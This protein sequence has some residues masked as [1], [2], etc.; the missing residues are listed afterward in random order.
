MV[1]IYKVE[2]KYKCR[3]IDI[4]IQKSLSNGIRGIGSKLF[5]CLG[6]D[7]VTVY[8]A[9]LHKIIDIQNRD[10]GRAFDVCEMSDGNFVFATYVGF[11]S[12]GTQW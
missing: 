6:E 4:N 9:T 3:F 11:F 12:Y 8:D 7:G 10:I 5:K 2:V 1:N